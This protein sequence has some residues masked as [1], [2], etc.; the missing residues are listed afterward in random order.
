M[1]C[2]DCDEDTDLARG[3]GDTLAGIIHNYTG[4]KPCDGCKKRQSKLNK[5]FPY[6]RRK[7]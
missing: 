1:G 4:I 7:P 5:W 2:K 3:V 6:K